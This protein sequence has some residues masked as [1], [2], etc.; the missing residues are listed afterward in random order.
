MTPDAHLLSVPACARAHVPTSLSPT[1]AKSVPTYSHL[2]AGVSEVK[3]FA[4]SVLSGVGGTLK[5]THGSSFDGPNEALAVEYPHLVEIY[6][7]AGRAAL[8]AVEA[9]SARA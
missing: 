8:L 3:G 9:R 7:K 6:T 4:G 2:L 1:H 5:M